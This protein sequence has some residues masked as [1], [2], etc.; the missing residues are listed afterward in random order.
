MPVAFAP[1]V[2]ILSSFRMRMTAFTGGTTSLAVGSAFSGG[3]A[4]DESIGTVLSVSSDKDHR[5]SCSGV[6]N[7]SSALSRKALIGIRTCTE[8]ITVKSDG[9][10]RS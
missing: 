1:V 5:P 9:D 8:P 10:H 7:L 2:S 4:L 3:S 6:T